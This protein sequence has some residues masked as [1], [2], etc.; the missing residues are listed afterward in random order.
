[1][2]KVCRI[3]ML[4]ILMSLM[5]DGISLSGEKP[6]EMEPERIRERKVERREMFEEMKQMH[7]K[8]A[9]LREAAELAKAEGRKED[10]VELR[11]QA[12]ML[13]QQIEEHLMQIGHRRLEEA[14]EHLDRLR[15]MTREAEKIVERLRRDVE[16]REA[17][18]RRPERGLQLR[19]MLEKPEPLTEQLRDMGNELRDFLMGHIERIDTVFREHQ[20]RMERTQ[21]QLQELLDENRQLSQQLREAN[22][23]RRQLERELNQLKEAQKRR[24]ARQQREAQ[25]R[26]EARQQAEEK[27]IEESEVQENQQDETEPNAF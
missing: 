13:N 25:Q 7:N 11:E 22:Q 1:M 10:V 15:R 8:L 17:S 16:R 14:E 21:R 26:K 2:K 9:E 4:M 18:R 19:P 12:K 23:T 6:E 27:K 20:T 5:S 3:F 24:E